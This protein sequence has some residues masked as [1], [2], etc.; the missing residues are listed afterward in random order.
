MPLVR[1]SDGTHV[2]PLID[3]KP[4]AFLPSN[5]ETEFPTLRGAVCST[6]EARMFLI[7]LG[8]TEP[9]PVDDVI[10]NVLQ[11]YQ[12]DEVE[13]DDDQYARDIERILTAFNTDSK[14]QREKLLTALR[15]TSF[16]MVKDAG[17]AMGYVAKP[18]NV[19]LAT[20]RLQQ[21]FAGVSDV[22][23]A[24]DEQDCLRGESVRELLE[25]CGA[26][27]YP[28]PI[29]GPQVLTNDER[30][31]LRRQAGHEQTS[32]LNDQ[33]EDWLLQ[34]FDDLIKI[35]PTL[36]TEQRAKRSQLI[37]ESLGDLEERR[38]RGIFDGLYKWSH[39]GSYRREFPSAF[40]RHLNAVAWVPDE[41]SELQPPRMVVFETLGWKTNPFLSTKVAFKP[42][43]I[44][45]L[46]KEAGIDPAALDLLRKL[47]ITS[48]ADL[49]SRLGIFEPSSELAGVSEEE[50]EID[51][52][53]VKDGDVYESAQDLYGDDMPD[54]PPGTPD[55]EGGDIR[56]F[57]GG[58]P[59][60][61]NGKG[62]GVGHLGFDGYRGG[63]SAGEGSEI[64]NHDGAKN[65]HGHGKQTPA[66]E[67]GRPFI[68]Y[69]GIHAHEEEPDPEGLDAATR[70]HIENRAIEIILQVEPALRRTPEGNP[71]FD[72][73]EADDGGNPTRWVEVKSMT[74]SLAAHAVGL[75]RAQFDFARGKGCAYWLY[76]VERATETLRSRV[77]RIQDPAGQARTF[78]F[79]RGRLGIA[80]TDPPTQCLE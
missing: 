36:P 52:D 23:I 38:G 1:L 12:L 53:P 61:G 33:V 7:A 58:A 63:G 11:K 39:Y 72:L 42:P 65:S 29:E 19:Y 46:A 20:D 69:I 13:I 5:I 45:Q 24:D 64:G 32:G 15:E 66:D 26:L 40:V 48:L 44:D 2:V 68:S 10:L 59:G 31:E 76:V 62:R 49:T 56:G 28:R 73:F 67:R 78:T 41:N 21:L 79:D 8:V 22:M 18:E 55:P 50:P 17:T 34:G 37:W 6:Q 3:N 60:G 35:L 75:S 14:I 16:V 27:R 43:I 57:T 30:K 47:G 4:K 51:S 25:A 77:L 70:K 74:A 9:D 80:R 54:I 71:G